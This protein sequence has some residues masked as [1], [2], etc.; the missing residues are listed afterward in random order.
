LQEN[1]MADPINVKVCMF[2]QRSWPTSRWGTKLKF[3][4]L[5]EGPPE[6]K[7][8]IWN[9]EHFVPQGPKWGMKNAVFFSM[10]APKARRET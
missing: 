10:L 1:K 2:A 7:E 9:P 6:P 8:K 3:G 5:I 4:K